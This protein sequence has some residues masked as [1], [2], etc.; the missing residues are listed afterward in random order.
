MDPPAL[1]GIRRIQNSNT[2]YINSAIQLMYCMSNVR[3]SV[4]WLRD[5]ARFREQSAYET[6]DA[7]AAKRE[8]YEKARARAVFLSDTFEQLGK[9]DEVKPLLSLR[10]IGT[11]G[12]ETWGNRAG[13]DAVEDWARPFKPGDLGVSDELLFSALSDLLEKS[14]YEIQAQSAVT[15]QQIS[16]CE[17]QGHPTKIDKNNEPQTNFVISFAEQFEPM[18]VQAKISSEQAPEPISGVRSCPD[19][20]F[21][22]QTTFKVDSKRSRYIVVTI[23]RRAAFDPNIGPGNEPANEIEATPGP[24]SMNTETDGV[25]A[26]YS[27]IGAILF[28][29]AHYIF[30]RSRGMTVTHI[31]DDAKVMVGPQ[32]EDYMSERGITLG[33]NAVA[34]LYRRVDSEQEEESDVREVEDGMRMESRLDRSAAMAARS[35]SHPRRV[36]AVRPSSPARAVRPVSH[37]RPVRPVSH[38]RAVR[39]VSPA[40][41]VRPVRPVSPARAVMPVRPA[42]HATKKRK[43]VPDDDEDED[44]QTAKAISAV[45]FLERAYEQGPGVDTMEL[46]D[47]DD[48]AAQRMA[49]E[50]MSTAKAS[51]VAEERAKSAAEEPIEISDDDEYDYDEKKMKKM[52]Y[53][54]YGAYGANG[55]RSTGSRSRQSHTVNRPQ[56]GHQSH[57]S[58]RPQ[59][60]HQRQQ[61]HRPQQAN[62]RRNRPTFGAIVRS[63]TAGV[64]AW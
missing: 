47:P 56:Q 18:T 11:D 57:Q 9:H 61:G 15:A 3:E 52:G 48:L 46:L 28:T 12:V 43:A 59:Q 22:R 2:C 41:A 8:A 4:R 39:P 14:S 31:Y 19:G 38:A 53:G 24:V 60:S 50:A 42:S 33:K 37:A 1:S 26:H 29:H 6:E 62:P 25:V 27:L 64:T 17:I 36:R 54:A 34:L 35:T 40:R 49:L 23:P 63:A 5:H 58:H 13:F 20:Q 45:D 55:E 30:A 51:R 10:R 16:I 7:Y 44:Y 21:Y 32:A